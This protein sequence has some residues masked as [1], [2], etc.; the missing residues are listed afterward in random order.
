MKDILKATT[1]NINFIRVPL[2]TI[3]RDRDITWFERWER[4][5]RSSCQ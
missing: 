3:D 5:R 4:R 1:I 2:I